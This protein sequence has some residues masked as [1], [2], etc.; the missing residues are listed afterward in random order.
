MKTLLNLSGHPVPEGTKETF[1]KVV[2]VPVPNVDL[3]SGT[4]VVKAA[5]ALVTSAL[6]T[7]AKEAILRGEV[8]VLLPGASVLAGAVLAVLVGV[9][10]IFPK[11][12]WAVR[13][14]GGF[15]LSE[16]LDLSGLRL[17]GRSFRG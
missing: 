7:E 11:L 17:E 15:V 6:E 2:S 5:K 10:G 14:E 3:G 9:S 16:E 8:A 4:A 12:Y 13:T 1:G